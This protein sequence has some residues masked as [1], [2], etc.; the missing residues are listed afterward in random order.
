MKCIL[1]LT[2]V[3]LDL[4]TSARQVAATKVNFFHISDLHLDTLYSVN[5]S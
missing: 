4:L 5:G 3:L 1:L 2:A